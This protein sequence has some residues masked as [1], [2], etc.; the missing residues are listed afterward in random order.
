MF[1]DILLKTPHT[2]AGFIISITSAGESHRRC[3][4]K[5]RVP[6]ECVLSMAGREKK[7]NTWNDVRVHYVYAAETTFN[8]PA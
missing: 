2:H 1:T 5:G 3:A 8:G 7:I 6:S 4:N